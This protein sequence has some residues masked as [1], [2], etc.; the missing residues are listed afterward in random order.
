MS[1][2]KIT[3]LPGNAS[4]QVA[5]GE[6]I[7]RAAMAAGVHIN[8]SCGGDGVCGKCRVIIEEGQTEGETPTRSMPRTGKRG[9][10]WRARL[11]PRAM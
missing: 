3:F 8:A 7:I 10:G 4:I 11:T 1:E 6:S 9:T 5:R 2:V